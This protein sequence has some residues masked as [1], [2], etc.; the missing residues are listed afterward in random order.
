MSTINIKQKNALNYMKNSTLTT[1]KRK[2]YKNIKKK[3]IERFLGK[4][5]TGVGTEEMIPV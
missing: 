2:K 5:S 3:I 4:E 1:E